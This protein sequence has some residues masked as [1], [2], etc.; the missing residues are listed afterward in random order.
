MIINK[1]YKNIEY[2]KFK[3][4]DFDYLSIEN[5]IEIHNSKLGYRIGKFIDKVYRIS[6]RYRKNNEYDEVYISDKDVKGIL[7]EITH[8]Q[9]VKFLDDNDFVRCRRKG[10]NRFNYNKKLWF[11]R[12]NREFFKCDKRLVEIE[13]GVLNKWIGNNNKKIRKKYEDVTIKKDENGNIIDEFVRYEL[14]CCLKTDITITDL[15][16]V[17]KNRVDNKLEDLQNESLWNW[18]SNKKEKKNKELLKDIN[19][20]KKNMEMI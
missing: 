20:W 3:I 2:L 13:E 11:F 17:I 14:E 19:V 9:L 10:N 1:R 15:N 12:L 4:Y 5:L 16:S 18:I 8:K 7:G 6:L